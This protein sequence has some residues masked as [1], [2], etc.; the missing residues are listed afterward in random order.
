M[1]TNLTIILANAYLPNFIE[2]LT[3]I[4]ISMEISHGKWP[5]RKNADCKSSGKID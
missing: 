1:R 2:F 3:I 5:K 4:K